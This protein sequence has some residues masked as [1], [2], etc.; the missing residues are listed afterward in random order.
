M[1]IE[2][3]KELLKAFTYH[4]KGRPALA[5][6]YV[7]NG[8]AYATDGSILLWVKV[9]DTSKSE[10]IEK[11][12][13]KGVENYV[14]EAEEYNGG[15]WYEAKNINQFTEKFLEKYRSRRISEERDRRERYKEVRCPECDSYVYWDAYEGKLV[16]EME[17]DD[18]F[19]PRHMESSIKINFTAVKPEGKIVVLVRY[20]YLYSLLKAFGD[21][22]LITPERTCTNP[23][24]FIK[25]RDGSLNGVLMP[26]H[27][28]GITAQVKTDYSLDLLPI[29]EQK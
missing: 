2:D 13:L 15:K 1:K 11:F 6:V 25:S 29:N 21:D 27:S 4:G 28:S 16:T 10:V 8:F 22:I 5:N 23:K 14:L 17:P 18:P 20:G 12:P 3:A 9:D 26:L 19:E 7:D 24:L